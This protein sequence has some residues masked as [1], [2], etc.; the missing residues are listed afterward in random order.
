VS[1]NLELGDRIS[2]IFSNHLNLPV[3]SR[4]TDLFEEGLLDSLAF[5]DLLV[6]LEREFGV[7]VEPEDLEF[8]HFRTISLIAEYVRSRCGE[9]TRR[10]SQTS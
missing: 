8:D 6:Q 2:W 7:V 3:P 9:V 4:D 5:V 10:D 1:E